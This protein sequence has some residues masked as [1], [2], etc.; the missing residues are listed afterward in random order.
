MTVP[1]DLRA[2]CE[3]GIRSLYK[4]DPASMA[5]E[6][7]IFDVTCR[8]GEPGGGASLYAAHLKALGE[9]RASSTWKQRL[10]RLFGKGDKP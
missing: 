1:P 9:Q 10:A 3:A 4:D 7:W 8:L 5:R 6:L 2:Q